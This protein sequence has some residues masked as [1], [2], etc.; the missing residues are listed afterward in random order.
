ME[1]D[2]APRHAQ[3]QRHASGAMPPHTSVGTCPRRA[4]ADWLREGGRTGTARR[5]CPAELQVR[6]QVA[7]PRLNVC[8]ERMELRVVGQIQPGRPAGRTSQPRTKQTAEAEGHGTRSSRKSSRIN[9]LLHSPEDDTQPHEL[10]QVEIVR[11][12]RGRQTRVAVSDIDHV[13]MPKGQ[14]YPERKVSVSIAVASLRGY[15]AAGRVSEA[16]TY[17][18]S[19]MTQTPH[20]RLRI[21]MF[22]L[23]DSALCKPK[24]CA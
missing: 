1:P 14:A 3:R 2:S 22:C 8:E 12:T 5:I 9:G 17:H 21:S 6:W 4:R 24:S 19:L 13:G 16:D 15:R 7:L 20:R 23:T 10:I 11:V 18:R